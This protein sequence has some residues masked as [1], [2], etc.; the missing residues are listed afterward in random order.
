MPR[1]R[2]IEVFRLLLPYARRP[3]SILVRL[4]D[5][6]GMDGWGEVCSKC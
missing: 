5:Y 2:E 6:G 3:E 1:V 4:V